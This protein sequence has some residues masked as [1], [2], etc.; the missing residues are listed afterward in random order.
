[1]SDL[2]VINENVR[3][4][5]R[6]NYRA[7]CETSVVVVENLRY[8]IDENCIDEYGDLRSSIFDDFGRKNGR[9]ILGMSTAKQ[10]N[11][12][13]QTTLGRVNNDIAQWCVNYLSIVRVDFH[14]MSSNLFN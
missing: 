9:K 1:M 4:L 6:I 12:I 14:R 8:V 13:A 2:A 5:G 10:P 3:N 11:I 7:H